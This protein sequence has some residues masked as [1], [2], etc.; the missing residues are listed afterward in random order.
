M[1]LET[2]EEADSLEALD[3]DDEQYPQLPDN[4]LDLRLYRRKAVLRQF[5]AAARSMYHHSHI[6]Y[7]ISKL[8]RTEYYQ[9]TGRIP[10]L[11]IAENPS[12]HLTKRSRPDTDYKLEEPS[13]MKS[14]GVD[15][16]LRHWLKLQKKNKRPLVLKERSDKQSDHDAPLQI[17]PKGKGKAKARDIDSDDE[18][19]TDY[20]GDDSISNAA[21]PP[22]P[23]IDTGTNAN[24][25]NH[26]KSLPK[27]PSSAA[28]NRMS[29]RTFLT[30]LSDDKNYKQ[31]LLLLKAANVSI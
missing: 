12:N 2:A 31:L 11:D 8:N 13:H 25:G 16:W 6:L 3:F 5:M 9:L 18:E 15:S 19:E 7:G 29:R 20:D 17:V 4:V 14:D 27:S 1:H 10:W 24:G 28:R 26:I 22:D 23:P 21:L 30:S